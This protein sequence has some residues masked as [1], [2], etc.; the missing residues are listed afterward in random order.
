MGN[1]GRL[2]EDVWKKSEEIM[3]MH[4]LFY[5]RLAGSLMEKQTPEPSAR[6]V[7]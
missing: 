3:K 6:L 2:T 5:I 4:M 1:Y 7:T